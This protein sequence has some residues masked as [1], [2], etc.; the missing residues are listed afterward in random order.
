MSRPAKSPKAA[1]IQPVCRLDSAH[2]RIMI[3]APGP[4]RILT[5]PSESGIMEFVSTPGQQTISGN[6]HNIG[7]FSSVEKN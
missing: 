1:V 7:Q 5:P 2:N 4:V 3:D 6:I